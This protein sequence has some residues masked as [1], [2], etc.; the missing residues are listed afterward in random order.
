MAEQHKVDADYREE[1]G[2][3]RDKLNKNIKANE[4]FKMFSEYPVREYPALAMLIDPKSKKPI[5]PRTKKPIDPKLIP[6]APKKKKKEPKFQ[7]PD[8]A[9]E[10]PQL[11]EKITEINRLIAEKDYINLADEK[12][13]ASKDDLA[14]INQEMKFRKLQE[15]QAQMDLEFK[16][17]NKKKK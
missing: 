16:N 7:V 8:W 17:A 3:L 1:A 10:I 15:E 11:Q 2:I 14:R 5:D 6:P 4:I 12:I 9:T 13:E